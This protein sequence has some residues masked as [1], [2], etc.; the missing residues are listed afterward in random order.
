VLKKD[1]SLPLSAK[2]ERA[3]L[4]VSGKCSRQ[5]CLSQLLAED[6]FPP[7]TG[8]QR[9]VTNKKDALSGSCLAFSQVS[10]IY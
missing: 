5:I 1:Q 6:L 10:L 9:H 8:V 2:R 4:A 3:G 7:L